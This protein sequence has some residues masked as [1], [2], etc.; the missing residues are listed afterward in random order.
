MILLNSWTQTLMSDKLQASLPLLSSQQN[1]LSS[2]P[3]SV[4]HQSNVKLWQSPDLWCP[5]NPVDQPW[6]NI[7]LKESLD[8]KGGS[9]KLEET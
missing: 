7:I 2:S 3:L 5:A 9:H 8:L 1:C 6:G 4:I